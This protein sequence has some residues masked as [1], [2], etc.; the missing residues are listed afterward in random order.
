MSIADDQIE[1]PAT[2]V[3]GQPPSGTDYFGG[4]FNV[5]GN[6]FNTGTWGSNG[7][8][9]SRFADVGEVYDSER[10]IYG[11]EQN[12]Q[13]ALAQANN[14]AQADYDSKLAGLS[15]ATEQQVA[16][17]KAAAGGDPQTAVAQLNS[18]INARNTLIQQKTAELG[19]QVTLANAYFGTN[20]IGRTAE[21]YVNEGY[22]RVVLEGAGRLRLQQYMDAA[23]QAAYTAKLLEAQIQ[24]LNEQLAALNASLV[25][26][27]AQE[28]ARLAAEA[29]AKRVADEQARIA[30]AERLAAEVAAKA[31]AEELARAA[32][33]LRLANTY[34]VSGAASANGP[35]LTTSVGTLPLI[36]TAAVTLQAAIRSAI[37]ALANLAAGTA[38]GLL[39]GVSAL[40]YSP[41]LANGELP[42]RYAL[43][44]PLSDLAAGSAQDLAAIAA[45]GGRVDLPVRI[46]SKAAADGQ[47]E[48]FVTQT[49]GVLVPS[50]V[51]VLA[52]T[53]DA[54][55]NVYSVT[56]ADTPPR[57]VTWTPIVKPGDSSTA[58]PAEQL[59][60]PVYTGA[61]VTPL[62][63]RID[64]FPAVVESSF[65]DFIT[66]FPADS[67]LPPLYVMFRD[68]REDAGVATGA[69][70][71]VTGSWLGAA[72]Q[73]GGAPIPARIADQLRGKTFSNFRTF[74]E[75]FWRAVASDPE[76]AA[77]FNA[78]S[79]D[80]MKNGYA[81]FVRVADRAGARVKIELHHQRYIS[82]GGAVYDLDNITA[83]TP[84][85]H[86]ELHKGDK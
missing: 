13:T 15:V 47:S 78:G 3:G 8:D 27:Q 54:E 81:P 4:G 40:V 14:P 16:A 50:G 48:V 52:A 63:G 9:P 43:S 71:V 70:Q 1:L 55:R 10:I 67:G 53:F 79:L 65:E 51:R 84:K 69:G 31:A 68:R 39:V 24:L 36:E 25:Q 60:P 74:R 64:S 85:H 75:T 30:E 12:A 77:Q 73:G 28:Q 2:Y 18:D 17:V 29:E 26:A 19:T 22:R 83:I 21:D 76:L 23:Y 20:P 80:A 35:L 42:E 37:S 41:K 6:G 58:L 57:T 49:D 72:S 82:N 56:T 34:R 86:I 66:V 33:E 45:A 5:S 61:T 44:T 59:V 11:L 32:E 38:S 62:E 7:V 46:G